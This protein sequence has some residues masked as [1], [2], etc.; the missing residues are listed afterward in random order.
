V[1]RRLFTCRCFH[2]GL[3]GTIAKSVASFFVLDDN[4]R[5]LSVGGRLNLFLRRYMFNNLR[6]GF[7]IRLT[8]ILAV[9]GD[10]T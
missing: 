3:Y 2:C 1:V 5:F 10:W 7:S 8:M 9:D 4:L 6:H